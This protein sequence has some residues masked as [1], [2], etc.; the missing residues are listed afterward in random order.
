M[1]R[2]I[3]NSFL[4]K[5]NSNQKSLI[6]LIDP[7]E[8]NNEK[9]FNDLISL[10]NSCSIDFF[11]VGGSLLKNPDISNMILSIKKKTKIPVILFPGNGLYLNEHADSVLFLSLISGRNPE[12]LIGQHV[13]VAKSLK[14][15]GMEVI[16]TGY[17][18]VDGGKPT[19]VS[20]MS[21]S[22]PIPGDKP[23]IAT[24]TALAGELLGMKMIYLEA[25]SGAISPV[26]ESMIGSVQNAIDVPLIVGGGINTADKAL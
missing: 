21:F 10:T 5:Y 19:S 26:S 4:E 3:L 18:L 22:Q 20:Y 24:S 17:I 15:S 23:E 2:K 25:G 1:T 12:L 6:V 7:D 13:I 11:F 9:K 14:E 8:Y 16:P